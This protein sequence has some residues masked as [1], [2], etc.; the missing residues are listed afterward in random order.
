MNSTRSLKS[1]EAEIYFDEIK[2]K[3]TVKVKL[4]CYFAKSNL[5]EKGRYFRDVLPNHIPKI[6]N[7]DS[8]E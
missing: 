4:I 2:N 3:L 8:A 7:L 5:L 6:L 1:S